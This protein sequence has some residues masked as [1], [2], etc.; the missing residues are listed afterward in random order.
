[1]SP[2]RDHVLAQELSWD[3]ADAACKHL[4]GWWTARERA[5][6]TGDDPALR[7]EALREITGVCVTCSEIAACALRAET[8]G[9]TGLA[10]GSAYL[11]GRIRPGPSAPGT[12]RRDAS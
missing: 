12:R 5:H 9:Y 6:A 2:Y 1:M 4:T 10:A 8:D 11:N 3:L 7:D